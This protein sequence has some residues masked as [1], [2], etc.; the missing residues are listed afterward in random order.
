MLLG[1]ALEAV[2]CV[3]PVAALVVNHPTN[4][5]PA[6][7]G[8][9][10]VPNCDPEA[11]SKVWGDTE[12]LLASHVMITGAVVHLAQYVVLLFG[13]T[14]EATI[15]VPPVASL[16]VNHPTNVCPALVGTGKLPNCVPDVRLDVDGETEPPLAFHVMV[17]EAVVH[18]AQ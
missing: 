11:N 13:T 16:V 5:C 10:K 1:T 18:L 6:L 4:V 2:I 3:P 8:V 17:T 14:L 7:V 12:P 9:G 15:C